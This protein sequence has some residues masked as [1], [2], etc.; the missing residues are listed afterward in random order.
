MKIKIITTLLIVFNSSL[1]VS[2]T[3]P[4]APVEPCSGGSHEVYFAFVS[5][6]A[7]TGFQSCGTGGGAVVHSSGS[8]GAMHSYHEAENSSYFKTTLDISKVTPAAGSGYIHFAEISREVSLDGLPEQQYMIADVII[9]YDIFTGY[10]LIVNYQTVIGSDSLIIDLDGNESVFDVTLAWINAG[11]VHMMSGCEQSTGELEI[12]VD[13]ESS[14]IVASVDGLIYQ[15]FQNSRGALSWQ[16]EAVY[17]GDLGRDNLEGELK[18]I[19]P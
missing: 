13:Y 15:N 3:S 8:Y 7:D 9:S 16:A 12:R 6:L 10:H 11:C 18:L 19:K 1:V 17:W 5:V 2:Q 4:P 14:E